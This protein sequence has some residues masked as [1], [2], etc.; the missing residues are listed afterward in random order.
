MRRRGGYRRRRARCGD[1]QLLVV[2]RSPI[3]VGIRE[4][5]KHKLAITRKKCG[6]HKE[7]DEI[8]VHRQMLRA[9]R[10]ML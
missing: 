7:R 2:Y 1:I 5:I 4:N 3:C 6:L 9:V 10:G 8:V